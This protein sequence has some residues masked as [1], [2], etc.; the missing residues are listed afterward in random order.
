MIRVILSKQNLNFKANQLRFP[1]CVRFPS[2]R[3]ARG[4]RTSQWKWRPF[5]ALTPFTPLPFGLSQVSCLLGKGLCGLPVYRPALH[6]HSSGPSDRLW[7]PA[8]RVTPLAWPQYRGQPRPFPLPPPATNAIRTHA[9]RQEA[10]RCEEAGDRAPRTG[11]LT[12]P[13]ASR[14]SA[15]QASPEPAFCLPRSC[16]ELCPF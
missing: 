16:I 3:D 12:W 2:G 14:A 1:S 10:R 9:H 15:S 11:G 7:A 4:F 8:P 5:S 6:G 13:L